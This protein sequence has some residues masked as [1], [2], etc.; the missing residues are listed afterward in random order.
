MSLIVH[1]TFA[2]SPSPV[3]TVRLVK[4]FT[5]WDG[6]VEVL[7]DKTWGAV[8]GEDW[9]L[10]NADV[11]RNF[12]KLLNSMLNNYDDLYRFDCAS[13]IN[14]FSRYITYPISRLMIVQI[15]YPSN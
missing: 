2:E 11:S 9:T 15:F 7:N 8:C 10:T 6:R 13:V 1:V 12:C 5:Q 14:G 4:G 3:V